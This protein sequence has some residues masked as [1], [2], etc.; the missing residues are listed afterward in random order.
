MPKRKEMPPKEELEKLYWEDGLYLEHIAEMFDVC[1]VTVMN[2]MERYGIDRRPRGGGIQFPEL[3]DTE[4]LIREY[5]D[6]E[7]SAGHIAIDIGCSVGYLRNWLSK[8][9]ITAKN[10]KKKSY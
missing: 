6:K 5:I 10:K 2:W 3:R 9:N 8:L 1:D 7:K 4:Y